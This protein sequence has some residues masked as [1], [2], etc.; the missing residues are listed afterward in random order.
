MKKKPGAPFV[1]ISF[2]LLSAGCDSSPAS[3]K[4]EL[5]TPMVTVAAPVS[6]SVTW[7]EYFTGRTQ[8]QELVDVRARVSG[9]LIKIYFTPGAEVKKGDPLFDIDPEPFKVDIA[10]VEADI[11]RAQAL[12]Q[13]LGFDLA[14]SEKLLKSG[15]VSREDYDK[16]VGDK[17]EAEA[18]VKAE[19]ARL[20][21]AKLNLGFSK[22]VSPIAGVVGDRL[23]TEGN[24]VISGPANPTLL[25]TIVAVEKMDV[26]F[27]VDENT[28][29][30]IQRDIREGK[31]KSLKRGEI[32]VEM[33][34]S[35]HGDKYPIPGKITFINNQV[36][37]KTGT[38]QLKA[39]FENPKESESPRLLT[40]GMFAR[41]RVPIGDPRPAFLVP[42]V[43][44]GSDQGSKFLYAVGA[45]NKAVRL[46]ASIGFLDG[47]LRVVESVQSPED[48]QPRPLRPD[49]QIIIGGLQRVRPG[50]KVDPKPAPQAP[51]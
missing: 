46:N 8:A 18:T 24:L 48:K 6:R 25:T 4:V 49:E 20:L 31:I 45:D 19:Q 30:R 32:P 14:R 38:I 23:V 7:Y 10:K 51:K 50:M 39:E 43:A 41:I 11:N 21:G 16:V 35:V 33:G 2:L 47:D 36:D 34:L 37:P 1:L 17:L 26:S 27:D 5:P 3:T 13:R 44:F 42:D 22:I 28:I 29:Q 15:A 40:A 12:V 9:Y